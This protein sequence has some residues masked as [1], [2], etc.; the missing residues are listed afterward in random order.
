MPRSP[1]QQPILLAHRVARASR[2]IQRTR[3]GKLGDRSDHSLGCTVALTAADW[4]PLN[5]NSHVRHA[6][7]NSV[8][9]LMKASSLSVCTV[10]C[11][12]YNLLRNS[13]TAFT[14]NGTGPFLGHG[15]LKIAPEVLSTPTS[16]V[17]ASY[18]FSTFWSGSFAGSFPPVTNM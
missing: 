10:T 1:L 11:S 2:K 8:V 5:F 18:S 3:Q 17:N 13:T 14:T 12:V 15:T 9:K 4:A 16:T 7:Q 6:L